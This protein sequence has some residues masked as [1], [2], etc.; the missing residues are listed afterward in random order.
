MKNT[1][2]ASA[3]ILTGASVLFY[4][5][6]SPFQPKGAWWCTAFS[7]MCGEA[8]GEDVDCTTQARQNTGVEYK[9]RIA[10]LVDELKTA[11]E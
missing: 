6:I 1:L 4:G 5:C 7:I 3:A 10:E 8:V 11:L 9:W 2:K